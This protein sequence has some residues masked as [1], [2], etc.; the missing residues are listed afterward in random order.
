MEQKISPRQ[1]LARF[2]GSGGLRGLFEKHSTGLSEQAIDLLI[3]I[4]LRYCETPRRRKK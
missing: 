2:V 4:A 1:E 3:H